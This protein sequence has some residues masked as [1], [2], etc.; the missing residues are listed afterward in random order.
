MSDDPALSAAADE[1]DEIVRPRYEDWYAGTVLDHRGGVLTVYRKPGSDLDKAVR[2]RVSGVKLVFK[3]AAMS[4]KSMLAQVREILADTEYWR[5][6]DIVIT[7]GG[8]L[9]DGS[10]VG[11]MTRAGTAAE[12]TRLSK[13]YDSRVV[14]ERGTAVAG[15]AEPFTPS[16]PSPA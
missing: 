3:D 14:V 13:H 8:P 4:E 16:T 7:G 11:I 15:P 1:V 10:G 12:A 5:E 9:N 6:R 2:S